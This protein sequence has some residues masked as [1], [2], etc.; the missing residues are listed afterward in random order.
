MRLVLPL[1][2]TEAAFLRLAC[3]SYVDLCVIWRHD[4]VVLVLCIPMQQHSGEMQ[5]RTTVGSKCLPQ[6]CRLTNRTEEDN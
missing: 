4:Y 5:R 6:S 1:A 3:L 2:S